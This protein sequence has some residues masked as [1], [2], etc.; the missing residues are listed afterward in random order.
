MTQTDIE[1]TTYSP[2]YAQAFARLND[3]WIEAYFA[4]EAQDRVVLDDPEG[5]IIAPGGQVFFAVHRGEAVGTVALLPVGDDGFELTKMAVAP[6]YQSQRL[7]KRL[8]LR[9]MEYAIKAGKQRLV[10]YSN[11]T[12]V[13]A[14]N[15]YLRYGFRP[16]ALGD[17]GGYDRANIKLELKL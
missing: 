4:I 2:A 13:A 12:L 3:Q 5:Q 17:H 14:I 9:A 16:I 7:G 10:I 11:T 1:L 6:A 15:L 8:M